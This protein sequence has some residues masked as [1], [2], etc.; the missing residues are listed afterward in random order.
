M[1]RSVVVPGFLNS[2]LAWSA[3]AMPFELLLPLV[4]WLMKPRS[5]T[6]GSGK[7]RQSRADLREQYDA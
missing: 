7:T 1:G 2:V 3:R 6:M 5:W 4:G